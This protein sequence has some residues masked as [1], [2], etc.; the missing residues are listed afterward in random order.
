[1]KDRS[2]I[3]QAT[4]A[5]DHRDLNF[6][7][8]KISLDNV[9][10]EIAKRFSSYFSSGEP[11]TVA[12]I[13]ILASSP[14]IGCIFRR[15][16]QRRRPGID[17]VYLENHRLAVGILVEELHSFLSKMGYRTS[18]LPEAKSEHST[19]DVL[20]VPTRFGANIQ[21]GENN[22]VIEV[23][24]GNSVSYSQLFRSLFDTPNPTM[25]LWRIKR[26][27]VAVIRRKSL[28]PMLLAFMRMCIF[29]GK[30]ILA[31][32]DPVECQHFTK[33]TNFSLS[34][35][36]FEKVLCDFAEALMDTLPVVLETVL[37]EMWRNDGNQNG[38][39]KAEVKS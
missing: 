2:P 15:L 10:S 19:I 4:V 36:E 21:N 34:S 18:V 1:M 12:I 33:P 22:I 23:K 6:E 17:A 8:L 20:I 14:C 39:R 28:Q 27:Q 31:E 24:T 29:R 25:V 37:R 35:K 9:C 5:T 38:A 7:D 3:N 30:R 32:T 13:D 16:N 11:R 26:H